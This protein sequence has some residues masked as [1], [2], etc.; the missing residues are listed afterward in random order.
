[1]RNPALFI[2]SILVF[3]TKGGQ[4]WNR[5]DSILNLLTIQSESVIA[6]DL[7]EWIYIEENVFISEKKINKHA[8]PKRK[9]TTERQ[10]GTIPNGMSFLSELSLLSRH[11]ARCMGKKTW[12]RRGVTSIHPSQ[13]AKHFHP[14]QKD[15]ST[16]RQATPRKSKR[17]GAMNTHRG[18]GSIG[19][20]MRAGLP[21]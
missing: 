13:K 2:N 5:I 15:W 9:N 7:R 16:Q 20:S 8:N 4:K 11:W 3:L 6:S 14:N 18:M 21:G 10:P 17:M 19:S 1:M 12:S